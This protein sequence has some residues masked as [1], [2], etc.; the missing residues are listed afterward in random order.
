[1]Q[2]IS[3]DQL[4]EKLGGRSRSAIYVDLEKGRLPKPLKLG[5]RLYWDDGELNQYLSAMMEDQNA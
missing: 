3:F 5:R 4:Q 2:Y 1:M